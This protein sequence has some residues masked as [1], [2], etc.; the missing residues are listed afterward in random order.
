MPHKIIM[1]ALGM[2]QETG[3]IIAWLKQEG[4]QVNKGDVLLEIETD[5]TTVELEAEHEGVLQGVSAFAGDEVPV[6]T[7]IG[8][9]ADP[10][11]AIPSAPASEKPVSATPVAER[12]AAE[13]GLALSSVEPMDGRKISKQDVLRHLERTQ[14]IDTKLVPAS[15]L[16]RRLAGERGIELAA[17]NGSGPDGA[18]LAADVSAVEIESKLDKEKQTLNKRAEIEMSKAWATSAARLTEA[19]HTIPHFYLERDIGCTQMI[20]WHKTANQSSAVKI[21]YTDLLVKCVASALREHPRLNASWIDGEIMGNEEINIGLA[22]AVEDGLLVPVV[23]QA[24]GLRLNQIAEK[25]QGLVERALAGKAKLADLQGGTFSISNLGMYGV[26]RFSAIV[27]PPQVAI[28]AVGNI[29]E[30][31]VPVDGLPVVRPMMTLTLSLDHRV[32]DGAR[33]AQFLDTL[34]GYLQEPLSIL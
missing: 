27:N 13:H 32:V 6:A 34:T 33:G 10:G 11:E 4:E 24:D 23:A 22:V 5:K 7:V 28:L 9:L 19:W 8:W 29:V 21:T 26:D 16:A 17:I 3:T 15:P 30:R 2:S 1:P 25:R 14:T 12:I 18:V 31:V 20:A